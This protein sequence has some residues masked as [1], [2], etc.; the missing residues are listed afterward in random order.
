VV[1]CVVARLKASD[2]TAPSEDE[3]E[4]IFLGPGFGES[5]LIHLGHGVWAVVDSSINASTRSSHVLDYFARIG[6]SPTSLEVIVATHWHDDHIRGLSQLVEAAPEARFVCSAAVHRKEFYTLVAS[7]RRAMTTISPGIAEMAAILKLLEARHDNDKMHQ[8]TPIWAKE[9]TLLFEQTVGSAAVRL[10][11]LSP[12]DWSMTRAWQS[13]GRLL[14]AP[15]EPKRVL[16]A[17]QSNEASVSLWLVVDDICILLGAD[18]EETTT[19]TGGWK[20]VVANPL[21]TGRASVF[22]IPH[23]GSSNG[24]SN[25]VW[26]TMLVPEPIAIIVPFRNGSVSLPTEDAVRQYCSLTNK[27]FL[28]V[29]PGARRSRSRRGAEAKILR[30]SG[31]NLTEVF[32]EQ[33]IVRLRIATSDTSSPWR[34]GLLPP[35]YAAC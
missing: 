18:L 23:H 27:L 29:R 6:V 1:D 15:M 12:S 26:R 34:V 32:S 10:Q 35:A 31:I 16:P 11:A 21:R 19:P 24:F 17:P 33:G 25:D 2:I 4:L 8:R 30:T 9:N 5:I 14:P 13:L 28:T 7:A 20:R 22:K 3:L